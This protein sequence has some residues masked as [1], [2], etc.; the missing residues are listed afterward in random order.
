MGMLGWIANALLVVGLAGIG[1][2]WRPSFLFQF[3]GE[4]LWSVKAAADGQAHLL[5]ICVVF[6][7]LAALNFYQWRKSR[8]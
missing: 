6:A 1:R 4:V 8:A 2:K 5:A 7:A 3:A